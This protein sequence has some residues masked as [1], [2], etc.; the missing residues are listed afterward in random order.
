[1]ENKTTKVL[2]KSFVY[3]AGGF[4]LA[5]IISLFT[6]NKLAN[7]NISESTLEMYFKSALLI[8]LVVVIVFSLLFR[9]LSSTV[10]KILFWI[11][12]AIDGATFSIYYAVFTADSIA[13][14]FFITAIIFGILSYVGYKTENDLTQYG[15]YIFYFL[16]AGVILSLID[17]WVNNSIYS[18]VID[19]IVLIEFCAVTIYD[20]NQIVQRTESIEYQEITSE[21]EK[22]EEEIEDKI[23]VYGAMQL[24]LDYVNIF[25]R[26]LS[27]F[28]K[29]KD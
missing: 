15:R 6:F 24:Y 29:R 4:L 20:V 12:A 2:R 9:K 11:Y 16:I 21:D 22:G 23:A 10:V 19:W 26:I 7:S 3:M 18:L 13:K 5:A 27:I 28:G 14:I 17:I 1:M 8:Q 25:L